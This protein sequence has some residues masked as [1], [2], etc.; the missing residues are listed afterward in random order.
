MNNEMSHLALCSAS[1]Q[2][3]FSDR[4]LVK[5][6][7]D[8]TFNQGFPQRSISEVNHDKRVSSTHP[9][10]RKPVFKLL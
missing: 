5:H 2:P 4:L 9:V 1:R 6:R 10:Y 3:F 7:I 8:P